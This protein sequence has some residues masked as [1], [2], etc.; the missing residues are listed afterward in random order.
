MDEKS[1]IRQ[2]KTEIP[3][4]ILE[5]N[6]RTFADDEKVNDGVMLFTEPL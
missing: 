5:S 3:A 4:W 1:L 6:G 2:A